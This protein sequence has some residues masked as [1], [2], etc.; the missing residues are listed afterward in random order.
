MVK[1]VLDLQEK[2]IKNSNDLN[3]FLSTFDLSKEHPD[4]VLLY[5]ELTGYKYSRG[6]GG[7]DESEQ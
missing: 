5:N 2:I 6:S 4:L 1:N 7:Q 3:E